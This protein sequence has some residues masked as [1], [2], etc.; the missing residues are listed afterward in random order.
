MTSMGIDYY[1]QCIVDIENWIN[2]FLYK[3]LIKL[4]NR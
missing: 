1:I 3:N 4:K 2:R